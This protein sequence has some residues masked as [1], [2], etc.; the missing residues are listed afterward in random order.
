MDTVGN[1]N[2][3]VIIY[4]NWIFYSNNEKTLPLVKE[5]LDVISSSLGGNNMHC[6]FEMVYYA[7]RYVNTK[8]KK[9]LEE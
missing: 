6:M 5:S 4:G 2:N 7:V 8:S 9:K 3:A 1:V